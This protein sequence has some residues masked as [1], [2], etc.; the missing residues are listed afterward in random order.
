MHASLKV[1]P[2]SFCEQCHIGEAIAFSTSG[3]TANR[4]RNIHKKPT[5]EQ[6]QDKYIICKTDLQKIRDVKCRVCDSLRFENLEK[7][8]EIGKAES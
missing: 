2:I 5:R 3:T 1:V 4:K 7:A 8:P 6:L